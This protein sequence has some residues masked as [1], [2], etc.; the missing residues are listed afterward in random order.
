MTASATKAETEAKRVPLFAE[1]TPDLIK[2]IETDELHALDERLHVAWDILESGEVKA[3]GLPFTKDDLA[4]THA[5]VLAEYAERKL[6]HADRGD[7][8]DAA[9]AELMAKRY[10]A[11]RHAVEPSAVELLKDLGPDELA[12]FEA[13]TNAILESS[14]DAA[15]REP[16]GFKIARW[17]DS[18]GCPR[19]LVCG[20]Y[21]PS[22]GVCH[23]SPTL[24]IKVMAVHDALM[25]EWEESSRQAESAGSNRV[26]DLE[27]NP[28]GGARNDWGSWDM[29]WDQKMEEARTKALKGTP[30]EKFL[31]DMKMKAQGLSKSAAEAA[32]VTRMAKVLKF[33]VAKVLAPDPDAEKEENE[34]RREDRSKKWGIR[35][36][37]DSA[38]TFPKG[39]P[40]DLDLYGDPVNLK[41]PVDTAA[42]AANAA[43]RFAQNRGAYT[44]AEQKIVFTRV[45]EAE[46]RH[47]I[48][49]TPNEKL[50]ALLPQRLLDEIDAAEKRDDVP[51]V[52]KGG[53]LP[54][55]GQSG[56]PASLEPVVPQALRWWKKRGVD[57]EVARYVAVKSGFL[58]PSALARV[59]GQVRRVVTAKH[60]YA[61]DGREFVE[62]IMLPFAWLAKTDGTAWAL[63][64]DRGEAGI[65]EFALAADPAAG[66]LVAATRKLL[67]AGKADAAPDGW[68]ALDAGQ[69]A[70]IQD[71]ATRKE[72][73]VHG[74][75]VKMVAVA[76]AD[77]GKADGPWTFAKIALPADL[78][79]GG[80]G[81]KVSGEKRVDKYDV[82]LSKRA[83]PDARMVKAEKGDER[84]VLGIVLEP[85]TVDG[86]G[87][88]Y[89]A[90]EVE[91]AA[92]FWAEKAGFTAGYMHQGDLPTKDAPILESGVQ[93]G[94][95][96]IGEQNVKAGT[97]VVARRIAND[98]LWDQ[99]KKGEI[100]GFSIGGLA[101]I[102]AEVKRARMAA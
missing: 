52:L 86:Q 36:L 46:I 56:L 63:R 26:V 62:K 64:L 49:P 70:L 93:R 94:A 95:F 40:Q 30:Y 1:V 54:P 84:L 27:A 45:V 74:A 6:D 90:Q 13:E 66:G 20:G 47:G 68:K 8:L 37:S 80:S 31:G 58:S 67:P 53:P 33:A 2:Q 51:E 21:K 99:V 14:L 91:R 92:H 23:A 71:G 61:G 44:E 25:R 50:R 22:S 101:E 59:D 81:G 87:D 15:A 89:S 4:R 11:A 60:V 29:V 69:A 97:W 16:H 77:G 55:D 42:R 65:E 79:A 34:K 18:G 83:R 9:T 35:V 98:D 19:C 96:K 3:D 32:R 72:M 17:S 28:S 7:G 57:A 76:Q 75:A 48:K 38:L 24:E 78:T 82:A 41:F 12:D 5:I 102:L 73:A 43:A 39:F 85:D 100:T 88:V 10:L